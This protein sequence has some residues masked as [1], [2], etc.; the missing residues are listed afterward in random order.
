MSGDVTQSRVLSKTIE[1][2]YTNPVGSVIGFP[3]ELPSDQTT[4][5][6]R[7]SVQDDQQDVEAFE[8]VTYNPFFGTD[9]DD[10]SDRGHQFWTRKRVTTLY[11][12]KIVMDPVY[13]FQKLHFEGA[14]VPYLTGSGG[15]T[16]DFATVNLISDN[17][18]KYWGTLA[19]SKCEPTNPAA[20]LSTFLGEIFLADKELPQFR[21]DD[22][23]RLLTGGGHITDLLG[24]TALLGEFGF[25]PFLND[26][27][28][29]MKNVQKSYKLIQQ[30]K[31]DAGKP[32]RRRYTFAPQVDFEDMD[33][34]TYVGHLSLPYPYSD[35]GVAESVKYTKY[36]RTEYWF[37]GSFTY[38]LP[39]GDDL[40]NRF[41]RYDTLA[42]QVLGS[43]FTPLTL[44]NITP[45]TWLIDWFADVGSAISISDSMVQHGLVLRYGYL[46]RR[47]T[48]TN[49]LTLTNIALPRGVKRTVTKTFS[50]VVKERWRSTPYGFG[51]DP[52]GFSPEQIAILI[53]LG[54]SRGLFLP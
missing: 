23:L 19:I 42:N 11:P 27:T 1:G 40:L 22:W 15:I 50:H 12:E 4:R 21:S 34:S 48:S 39:I 44:W 37:S 3:V 41:A 13:S 54:L 49:E 28:K 17:D 29:L 25:R 30:Y 14:P 35:V 36:L 18:L 45:W 38:A 33:M 51:L 24:S 16:P 7:S 32:V 6:F 8:T 10:S 26:V 46:M 43:D 9:P 52:A 53:S 2:Y 5:S 31:K 47:Q 20:S